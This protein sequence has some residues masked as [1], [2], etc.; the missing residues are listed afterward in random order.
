MAQV[1]RF[2]GALASQLSSRAPGLVAGALVLVIAFRVA[3]LVAQ[4]AGPPAP[5]LKISAP[6]APVVT[7]NVVD[8]P[9]ILR[10]NLFGQSARV[11]GASDA[12]VTTMALTLAGVTAATDP[13][14]PKRG[15]AMIGTSPIDVRVYHVG[16]SLPGGAQLHSVYKDR[17]LLDRS[18]SIE[19]LLLPPRAGLPP[20]PPPPP[21]LTGAVPVGR[22]QQLMRENPGILNQVL[23]RT[24]VTRDGKLVGMRVNPGPNRPAFDKL[25]LKSG[26]LITAINGLQLNDTTKVEEVFNS[27]SSAAEANVSVERNGNRQE[28]HLNLAEIANEAERLTQQ[29]P[30]PGNPGPPLGPESTR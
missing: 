15:S 30:A 25:G 14:D 11:E 9:S 3:L 22:V 28:L 12:P 4:M 16:A 21:P 26:D 10:A 5:P 17:V 2:D 6:P 20:P 27:L 19:A 18:G 24:A 7:R 23:I 29:A 1:L 8:V 13:P